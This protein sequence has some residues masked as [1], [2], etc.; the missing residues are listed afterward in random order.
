MTQIKLYA[1]QLVGHLKSEPFKELDLHNKLLFLWGRISCR[2][3]V[4]SLE[5]ELN[6]SAVFMNGNRMVIETTKSESLTNKMG[7]LEYRI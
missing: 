2:E 7:Q 6:V 4:K 1:L 3:L 5:Q